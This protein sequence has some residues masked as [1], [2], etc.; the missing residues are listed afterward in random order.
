MEELESNAVGLLTI[1]W[2]MMNKT[3]FFGLSMV[4][5]ISLRMVLYPLTVI[6]T[7]LQV[8]RIFTSTSGLNFSLLLASK[9]WS[10]KIQ[11]QVSR[12]ILLFFDFV[13]FLGTV[14]AFK[15]IV[16]K[17]GVSGLYKGNY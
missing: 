9:N 16:R 13:S 7:R 11:R 10:R 8:F 14:D 17:E 12:G 4:H 15:S 2:D 6:K 3:R 5:S 1:E